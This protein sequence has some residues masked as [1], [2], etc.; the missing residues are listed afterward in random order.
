M[1]LLAVTGLSLV[2]Q[3]GAGAL[4][5]VWAEDG[6]Q[7]LQAA[8][9][10]PADQS[11]PLPYAGYHH[12]LPRLAAEAVTLLPVRAAA[13]ALAV[14]AALLTAVA[15]TTVVVASGG[16]LRDRWLRFGLGA[17]VVA[18]PVAGVETL[19]AVALVQW[20]LA[21]AAFWL[22]LWRPQRVGVV[23]AGAALLVLTVLSAP[24]SVGLAPLF[25]LRLVVVDGWR[26]RVFALAALPAAARQ[27]VALVDF[28]GGV[29]AGES[30]GEVALAF[31][32]RV[33]AVGLLGVRLSHAL[34]D[35]LGGLLTVLAAV[36]LVAL[37][38]AALRWARPELRPTVFVAAVASPA[39]FV[40]P[41]ASRGV[42][43]VMRWAPRFSAI[44]GG[45]RYAVVPVLL[46]AAVTALLLDGKSRRAQAAVG[47]VV[48][49]LVLLDLRLPN[50][51]AGGPAWRSAV[52]AAAERCAGRDRAT[53]RTAPG[54][55]VWTVDIPCERLEH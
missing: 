15:A 36:A 14:A 28:G 18:V 22:T 45:A 13:A 20:P 34:W 37:V 44:S 49:A 31:L 29:A 7:F 43:E 32:Q 51:R 55:A 42:A 27:A 50:E 53:V 11:V 24:L 23:V 19:N 52:S 26:D 4:D 33:G 40:L 35:V 48:L 47:A 2:R 25:L 41:V 12:A 8:L 39:L 10:L 6:R 30:A 46:L 1:F 54:E 21:F 5:T 3:G 38:G 16:H 9:L 17:L